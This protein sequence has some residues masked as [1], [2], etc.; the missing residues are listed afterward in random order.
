[1]AKGKELTGV[2]FKNTKSTNPKA[3]G[4]KGQCLIN[5]TEFWISAWV[6]EHEERGKYFALKFE[7]KETQKQTREQVDEDIPF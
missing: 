6:N 4:Y 7:A 5:G 3:P 1:M 2:I